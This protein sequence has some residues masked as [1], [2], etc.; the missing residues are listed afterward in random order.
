MEV[1]VYNSTNK[2]GFVLVL[3]QRMVSCNI[4]CSYLLTETYFRYLLRLIKFLGLDVLTSSAIT[5]GEFLVKRNKS[6][7]DKD[8]GKYKAGRHKI[9]LCCNHLSQQ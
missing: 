6:L 2:K 7:L 9:S 8:V 5:S 4:N 3:Y 1:I